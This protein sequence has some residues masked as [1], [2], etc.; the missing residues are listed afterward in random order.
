LESEDRAL[1]FN[2]ASGTKGFFFNGQVPI[3]NGMS[4]FERRTAQTAVRE[5]LNDLNQLLAFCLDFFSYVVLLCWHNFLSEYGRQLLGISSV[6]NAL[7]FK[8]NDPRPGLS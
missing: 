8:Y 7:S 5:V 2:R 6:G 4:K 3:V 1:G